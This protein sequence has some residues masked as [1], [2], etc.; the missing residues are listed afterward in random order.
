MKNKFMNDMD[1]ISK[2]PLKSTLSNGL[3]VVSLAAYTAKNYM[4][5]L[6]VDSAKEAME[7]IN[8]LDT[9][10]STNQELKDL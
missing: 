6:A 9:E 5:P 10:V 2:S 7:A 8:N 4:I 3:Q 1:N